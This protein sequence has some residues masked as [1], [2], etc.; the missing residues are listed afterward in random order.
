[1]GRDLWPSLSPRRNLPLLR[2]TR[3]TRIFARLCKNQT[4]TRPHA[5]SRDRQG[6][7]LSINRDVAPRARR[8]APARGAVT[9][10]GAWD[11]VSE[12]AG[13]EIGTQPLTVGRIEQPH[14]E[15]AFHALI[16]HP[17]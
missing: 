2:P 7:R 15:V 13:G 12:R 1:M 17:L 10:A 5:N 14:P 3:K 8:Q 9:M 11:S 16:A 6:A 4:S